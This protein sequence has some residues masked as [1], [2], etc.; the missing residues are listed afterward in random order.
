MKTYSDYII[1]LN[2]IKDAINHLNKKK[3]SVEERL[4]K[5]VYSKLI[6]YLKKN[7]EFS[8]TP[9]TKY[10]LVCWS[11]SEIDF[12]PY[13]AGSKDVRVALWFISDGSRV[14]CNPK[15]IYQDFLLYPSF[16]KIVK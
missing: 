13:V 6:S 2:L 3:S 12:V 9:R 4:F 15:D 5:F 11:D 14:I 10:T 16:Q 1:E 8:V 7:G